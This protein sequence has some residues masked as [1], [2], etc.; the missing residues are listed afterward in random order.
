LLAKVFELLYFKFFWGL[1]AIPGSS[2]NVG[3][4]I[5]VFSR[6]IF[7][8]SPPWS[9]AVDKFSR[10]SRKGSSKKVVCYCSFHASCRIH[11]LSTIYGWQLRL[12][13]VT[14]SPGWI[15]GVIDI[16]AFQA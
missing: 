11:F 7:S 6:L 3:E 13:F 9:A 2:K 16:E 15:P 5:N 12:F 4:S 8:K 14:C 1:S 10:N